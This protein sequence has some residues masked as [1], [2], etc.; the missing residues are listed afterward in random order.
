MNF[1]H[2]KG[3]EILDKYIGASEENVRRLFEDAE[4]NGPTILFFDEFDSIVPQRNSNVASITDRIVNQFLVYLDG[5]N[6]LEK[7]FVF[8]AT[9][10]P[11]M[12][13]KA[14]LRPGRIDTHVFC[15]LPTGN[16]RSEHLCA[17]LQ[18]Y[19][20]EPN[21]PIV[22]ELSALT[23]G[24]SYADLQLIFKSL[25]LREG[26]AIEDVVQQVREVIKTVKPVSM[27][28]DF[29]TIN[30]IYNKFKKNER[31]EDVID[32]KAILA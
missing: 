15:D 32:Q 5:V 20:L 9:S 23:E 1:V 28:Q 12:I 25:S 19:G 13:D 26:C 18:G 17:K 8:A 31:T 22:D 10:R 29:A 16:E 24:F 3:P 2:V 30:R 7:T 14:I 27:S 21:Q 4:K 6:A 11:D